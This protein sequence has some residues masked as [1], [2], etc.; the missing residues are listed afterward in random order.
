MLAGMYAGLLAAYGLLSLHL[1]T[2]DALSL[3]AIC[4]STGAVVCG[5]VC[6]PG[7]AHALAAGA[8]VALPAA[9]AL[10]DTLEIKMDSVEGVLAIWAWLVAGGLVAW[11]AHVMRAA[12]QRHWRLAEEGW[13]WF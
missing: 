3:A 2:Y 4:T 12:A 8:M 10:C 13:V 9:Y 1:F 5:C 6:T 11:G 7:R